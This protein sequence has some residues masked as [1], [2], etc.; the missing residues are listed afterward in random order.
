MATQTLQNVETLSEA[1]GKR[2]LTRVAERYGV[3][4]TKLMTTLKATA[5]KQRNGSA[6]TEEQ[7][8]ALLIVAEQ[9]QLNP[10]TREIYAFPDKS[11]GIVPV[12]GVDGW[13]RIVN[14]HTDYQGMEF[15]Y[16]ETMVR[17]QGAKVDAHEW[18]ECVMYRKGKERPTIVREYLDEV[19][20]EPFK[21]QGK[22]YA[23]DGPWQTHPKRFLRH[24]AMIQCARLAFG[25]VGIFDQDEAERISE[26]DISNKGYRVVDEEARATAEPTLS[27]GQCLDIGIVVDRLIERAKP[28]NAWQSAYEWLGKRFSGAEREYAINRLREAELCSATEA[29]PEADPVSVEEVAPEAQ[30]TEPEEYV[31]GESD[32]DQTAHETSEQDSEFAGLFAD[33]KDS[34]EDAEGAYIP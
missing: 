20:R 5:F 7:M 6:P 18:I 4:E 22:N 23:V 11:N 15:N 13:S 2:L 19:Y 14:S 33:M 34:L 12:V 29:I 28:V 24:K 8:M 32:M 27:T 3:D 21:P 26:I 31:E 25:F 30:T 17:P 9:Y 10:F 16:S 1:K